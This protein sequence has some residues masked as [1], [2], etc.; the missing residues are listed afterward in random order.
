MMS[1]PY[2][3][4][5]LATFAAALERSA[6]RLVA[7]HSKDLGFGRLSR[8]EQLP[9]R[10]QPERLEAASSSFGN[11]RATALGDLR[12]GA[13]ETGRGTQMNTARAFAQLSSVIAKASGRPATFV[14]AF[15]IVVAWGAS[16]PVFHVSDT[17]QL[18]MNTVSSI[19]T[20]LMVFL[21]QNTQARDSEAMH[22]KLDTIIAALRDADSRYIGVERLPDQEIEA[23]RARIGPQ[24]PATID[25]AR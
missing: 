20:F 6:R 3:R 9:S 17:W 22:A 23:M 12:S 10:A 4:H 5:M 21:I 18:V 11:R 7:N 16:G 19:I 25:D 1:A 24:P 13:V 2:Q 15:V 14:A 8:L